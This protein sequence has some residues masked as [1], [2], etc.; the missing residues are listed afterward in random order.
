MK[1]AIFTAFIFINFGLFGQVV[2]PRISILSTEY[3]FGDIKQG[4]EVSH[5]FKITNSGG[6][7]LRI[8]RIK[9]SCGCTAASPEKKIL[10][11]GESTSIKVKFDTSGRQGL[12]KKYV[13][14]QSNDP[15]QKQLRLT[16]TAN[17]LQQ[18]AGRN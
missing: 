1:S 10:L 2:G 11:P 7:S 15:D 6:D 13:Y 8:I 16:I 3:N 17:V 18:G 9:S 14:V 4:T 12:Q 5:E